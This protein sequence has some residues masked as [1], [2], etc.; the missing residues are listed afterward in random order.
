MRVHQL[1]SFLFATFI[2]VWLSAVGTFERA[3][4]QGA[5]PENPVPSDAASIAAGKKL[6]DKNCAECHGEMGKGDGPRA[7]YA[8]PKPPNLTDAEW[9]HGS[10]DGDIF[11]VIQ[12]GVKDTDMESFEKDIPARQLWDLVNYVKSLGTT[13]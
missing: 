12:K 1:F 4:A 8:S 5:K 11:A 2:C 3:H 7:P 10:T 9:K 13:K 6:Y